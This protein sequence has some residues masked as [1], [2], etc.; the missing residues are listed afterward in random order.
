MDYKDVSTPV[1]DA[2]CDRINVEIKVQPTNGD[3]EMRH[4]AE[5][6]RKI[7]ANKD[8]LKDVEQAIV[9]GNIQ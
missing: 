3:T 6:I 9:E 7:A 4:V 1:A 8:E 5:A 2:V